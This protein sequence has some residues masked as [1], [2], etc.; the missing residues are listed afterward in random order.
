MF[1]VARIICDSLFNCKS[2]FENYSQ[3]REI[4]L[5]LKEWDPNMTKHLKET[6]FSTT[7]SSK[8]RQQTLK[9][10]QA[11]EN[12]IKKLDITWISCDNLH[13]LL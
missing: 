1:R 2:V 10:K 4:H 5:A 7:I 8:L 9:D 13:V 11:N 6:A 3:L 12:A